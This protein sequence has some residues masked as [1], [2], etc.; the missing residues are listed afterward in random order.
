MIRPSLL[1]GCL[2]FAFAGAAQQIELPQE[3]RANDDALA[4][5]MPAFAERILATSSTHD[6]DTLFRLQLAAGRYDDALTSLRA[7]PASLANVRWEI[8][9]N[10]KS[11]E[12]RDAKSF[13]DAFRQSFRERM[14][15]LSDDHAH[16]VLWTFGTSLAFLENDFRGTLSRHE[17]A[18]SLPLADAID[19]TKKYL[20]VQAYRSFTPLMADLTAEDDRR[21]Y[22]VEREKPIRVRGGAVLCADIVRPRVDRRFPALLNFTIYADAQNN[23]TE[24]RR[25]ASMGYAGVVGTVRGKRCSPGTAVPYERDSEDAAALIDWIA[26]QP[27][28]DGRVGMYGGSYEGGTAWA[29]A[30]RM[31]KALKAIMTGA[32]V[33]PGIDVPMEGNIF[34]NFVYPFPFYTTN[35]KTLDNATYNDSARWQRLDREWYANGRAYRDLEKID[36]TPNPVFRTWIAHPSYDGYWRAMIPFQKEFARIDIPVLTTAGYYYGGPGAAVHYFREHL[37][38]R[39]NA[40][41]YLLI[42]PYDHVRGHS[43]TINLLGRK[44]MT[45][46]AGYELEPAAHIDMGELRYQ[47]FDY[48]L[49]KGPKPAL[50]TDKVNYFVVGANQWKHAPSLAAMGERKMK[51]PLHGELTV[52]LGDR[53]D[54]DR[55]VPGG[56]VVDKEINLANGLKFVSEP[57]SAPAEMSGLFSGHFELITNKKDFDFNVSLYELTATGEYRLLA[58]YWS[59]A[60]YTGHLSERRLL[61]PGQRER[62]DFES[63]RLM[64]QQLQTG[65]RIVAV[66]SVIKESGRQINYGSGQDVSAESSADAGE[67]LHIQW[68]P[69]SFL[70]LPLR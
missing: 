43:G 60:S 6:P 4:A 69:G 59:R 31:P 7:I 45:T 12:A 50:L 21:R 13:G 30:K 62:L 15:S 37:K 54:V 17:S 8:Y 53:S 48:V 5:A 40:E 28:S 46:L 51:L 36:G 1:L 42:G 16:R 20:G 52:N 55:A 18:S 68:M 47:W 26:S 35:N 58:P 23:Y 38:Y 3:S 19:L 61:T 49:R 34:W 70:E 66:I 25:S 2:F 56:G 11:I 63:A 33:A 14:R 64:S 67:P 44:T 39:P 29:A 24:A 32:P 22:A 9:A 27:W 10:A 65:S 57:L 41:H